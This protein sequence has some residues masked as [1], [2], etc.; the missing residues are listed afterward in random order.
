MF[1]DNARVPDYLNQ[2]DNGLTDAQHD[3]LLQLSKMMESL[4]KTANPEIFQRA[5]FFNNPEWESIRLQ[6]SMTRDALKS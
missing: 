3:A 5:S 2:P 1:F 6:A 4:I